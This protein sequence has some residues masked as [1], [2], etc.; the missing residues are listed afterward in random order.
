MFDTCLPHLQTLFKWYQN[1]DAE[2]GFC[3]ETLNRLE[4]K[5]KSSD[6]NIMCA[7]VA[8]EMS[9]RRQKIWT[10]KYY[11]GLVDIGLE[12]DESSQIA[13]Q[14]YVFM[15]VSINDSW[16]LPLAYFFVTA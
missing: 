7:L 3:A 8:D 6:K 5:A 9:I 4:E 10:G 1:V 14:A 15:L 13:T 16:K 12:N 11:E 2:P